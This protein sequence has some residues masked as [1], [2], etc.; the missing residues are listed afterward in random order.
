ME[1]VLDIRFLRRI[2]RVIKKRA[3]AGFQIALLISMSFAIAF[4]LGEAF[5]TGV[6]ERV[7]ADVTAAITPAATSG[8]GDLVG[9]NFVPGK[10]TYFLRQSGEVIKAG[11]QGVVGSV[12]LSTGAFTSTQAAAEA[13]AAAQAAANPSLI[14]IQAGH[15]A[16]FF[17]NGAGNGVGIFTTAP[18]SGLAFEGGNVYSATYGPLQSA[19]G[20]SGWIIDKTVALNPSQL[21][22]QIINSAGNFQGVTP[23]ALESMGWAAPEGGKLG[24]ASGQSINGLVSPDGLHAV[25]IGNDETVTGQAAWSQSANAGK[26]AWTGGPPKTAAPQQAGLMESVFGGKAFGAGVPGAGWGA[27]LGGA[28]FSGLVW[29]AVVFG[30]TYF[31]AGMFGL[32]D[33]QALSVATGLGVGTFAGSSLY[34]FGQNMAAAGTPITNGF[35]AFM[36]S[37]FGAALT[38]IGI[39]AVI[40]IMTYK[41]QKKELVRF[42]CLP[43]EAPTGGSRC[44]ECNEDLLRPCSEYRCK[45]L[46]QACEIVNPGTTEEMCIW[47]GKGDTAGP[48]ITPWNEALSPEGLRYFPDATISPPNRGFEVQDDAG[49]DECLPA[50]TNLEFGFTTDE[51]AQCKIDYKPSSKYDE[52]NT[53]FVGNT[54]LFV[55]EHAQQIKVMNTEGDGDF[56]PEIGID[57]TFTLWVRC[58]DANG[59]GADGAMVA[60]RYC[61]D[62][63]PDTMAPSVEGSFIQSGSPVQFN[64][65]SVHN[66]IYTNEPANCRW[67]RRDQA[68]SNM[69]NEMDCATETYNV[70]ADLNY[71]CAADLTGIENREENWFY[72]RCVDMEGNV[73]P[74]SYPLM[75][76]GTEELVIAAVGPT[77]E[78]TGST[79]VIPVTLTAETAHGADE[80]K[81]KCR[82]SNNPDEG[83]VLMDF[84]DD[85]KHN[86]S[87]DLSAGAYTYYFECFDDGGNLATA[88]TTFTV[89]VDT[90]DPLVTRVLRDGDVLKVITSEEAKCYYS[91]TN[92]NYNVED[93]TPMLYEDATKRDVHTAEWTEAVTYYIKCEDFQGNQPRPDEC[94]I[95]AQ[96]SEL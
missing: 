58:I 17:A 33:D 92:C 63:G 84:T 4:I 23:Q 94:Q 24:L 53:F 42:E 78:F 46:G 21:S 79:S 65:D 32:N 91:T 75:L 31:L 48:H 95:I 13:A 66:E 12:D 10:G 68:Y 73:M 15:T 16:Q 85:Y 59:N 72:F 41:T 71:V 9:G 11:G 39:A 14:S 20:Q 34:L 27:N 88:N 49:T 80:G 26:G 60:F 76:R 1:G 2:W 43:W 40:I 61:V 35:G 67:S 45:S 93:S 52:M 96:A 37:G 47:V 50:F 19:P 8:W 74:T 51:P 81:A 5:G 3:V 82:I 44:A 83:F 70:N 22:P 87:L 55:Q 54:N 77:G 18:S 6:G 28:L 38:G 64:V 86:Q 90:V 30:A 56:V 29:G 25:T 89:S 69:E 36:T 57:G 62:Q 7:S